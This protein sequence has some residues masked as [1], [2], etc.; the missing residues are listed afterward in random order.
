MKPT[1]LNHERPLLVGMIQKKTPAECIGIV[2]DELADG[3]DAFGLQIES[4]ERKYRTEKDIK[5]IYEVMCGRP[6]YVTNYRGCQNKGMSDEECAEGVLRALEYGATIGD[7]MGDMFD[8]SPLENRSRTGCKYP[9]LSVSPAAVEKQKK[10]I[11]KIHSMGK[12]VL[13]SSHVLEYIPAEQT[14]E[15]AFEQQRRGA[16]VVKIVTAANSPEEEAENIRT[17]MLLKKE[18][19]VPFLFL[20]GGTHYKRHR[21]AGPMFGCGF[22]L[23][24]PYYYEG[25]T[26]TQPTLRNVRAVMENTKYIN[27]D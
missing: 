7:I 26:P 8:E 11:D 12:E 14:L 9:E 17:T 27:F 16:D 25:S 5:S 3:A 4:I 22:Y 23:C 13:M 10:L 24:V 18:L 1:F 2:H 6:I 15:I 20:S 19:K 21:L